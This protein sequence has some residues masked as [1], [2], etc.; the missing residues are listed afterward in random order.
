MN[1]SFFNKK[2]LPVISQ[3]QIAECGLTSLTMIFQF[4]G[5]DVSLASLREKYPVS[6]QGQSLEDLIEICDNEGFM[7]DGFKM[8][9]NDFHELKLPAVIHWDLNHFVVLKEI[10]NGI[11][12][13]HDPGL[14]KISYS[15]EEFSTHFTGF[16]LQIEPLTTGEFDDV[17]SAWDKK[18]ANN[19]MSLMYFIRQTSGFYKS[20]SFILFMTFV[21]QLLSMSIPSITQV[22]IDDFIVAQS[23]EYLWY[24][25]GGGIGILAFRYFAELIKSW[26]VIFIGYNW[27]ANFS[28]YFYIRLL[29]LPLTYFESRSVSDI[30]SRFDALDELKDALTNRIVQGVID[31][32]MSIITLTAMFIYSGKMALISLAFL[33]IYLVL[34]VYIVTKEMKANKRFI[35]EKVKETNSFYDTVSN[36]LSVKIYGKESE[37]YQQ[38]KKH[39]LAAANESVVLSKSQ[40]WYSSSE[41]LLVGIESVVLM[42]VAATTVI[43]GGI[44]LGMMF[45]FFA[46]QLLFSAQSKS[47]INNILQMKLLGVHL[48]RLGDIEIQKIEENL[49][50]KSSANHNIKGKIEARN[51]SFKYPGTK[52]Y[53][54]KNFSMVIEPGENIV[55]SG[56]SGC[57][58]TTLMKIL[59]GLIQAEE[60][61]VLVDGVNIN[62]MGLKNYRKNIAAVT[63]KESLVSGSVLDNIAFFSKPINMDQVELSIKQA[64]IIDDIYDM[65]MQL[66]TITGNGSNTFSGGQEQRVL[67]ARALY[68]EPKILFMDEATSYLDEATEKKIVNTLKSLK[69]TR[70]SIAHRKETIAM[71]SRIIKL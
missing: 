30:F 48:D 38:W 66:Q 25:I 64:C 28:S 56:S 69:M 52:K 1:L 33:S 59:M 2:T 14:G 61:E 45:A 58:K 37:R 11:F 17:K 31:G 34:R 5:L 49:L 54:L 32:L 55:I 20:L 3:D 22:I 16:S 15:E 62:N 24:F 60:G 29:K 21:A 57:G 23:S 12:T 46:Y 65:P 9:M 53:I 10:N 43:N 41:N 67:L 44:S 71:A 68:K 18:D 63:Q 70:I 19:K 40:M 26:S 27:H 35:L 7:A 42:G 6:N 8:E 51:I 39:Y 47:M 4:H 50:G 36:I 13:I